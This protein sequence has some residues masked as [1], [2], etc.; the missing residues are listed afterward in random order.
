MQS[1]DAVKLLEFIEASKSKGAGDEFLASFLT[2]RGWPQDDVYA[3][4]GSYW[5]RATGLAVP[6]RAAAGE[7]SRDAFLYLLSFSTL[8]TWSSALGS[9]LF[10][11]IE[12][13]FPDA[14]TSNQV[15]NL[16]SAVTWQMASVAVA[17]PIFLLVM[18]TILREAQIH[19]ERLQSSVRKWLTY[20]ALL[21]TA[22]AVICDLIW[23]FDYFLTGELTSRFLLKALTVMAICG[24]IFVYY[25]SSLR[26]DRKT[27]VAQAKSRSLKFGIGAA[28]AVII[29]FCIGL[30]VAGTPHQ[31]RHAEADRRR[32]EDLRGIAFAI[33]SWHKRAE[34][35][36]SSPPLPPALFALESRGIIARQIADPETKSLYE[37]H[38]KSDADY[39][40]CATF[41]DAGEADRL[42]VTQF[43]HHGRGRT[44][45][46]LDASQPLIW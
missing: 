27:N 44:C 1:E 2:R 40:L 38:V 32:V 43:W 5:E 20:I 46:I 10:R 23:F 15:Y 29:T 14:V 21:L 34:V 9:M 16:R 3:A 7:S 42:P 8:A 35:E 17:F 37:Y 11:F 30:G 45:F 36:K 25:L 24:T 22:G 31:Q 39:E 28:A 41:S 13:W 6:D 26:W 12:R 33:Y 4:L 19:P 18:R